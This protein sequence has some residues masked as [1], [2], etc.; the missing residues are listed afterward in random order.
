MAEKTPARRYYLAMTFGTLLSSQGP[1]AQK[2]DPSALHSWLDVQLYAGFQRPTTRGSGPAALP[3]RAAHG[4]TYTTPEGRARGVLQRPRKL[5]MPRV[6]PGCRPISRTARSTPGMK[7]ARSYE[8]CRRVR[9]SPAAPI[10]TSWC[11]TRPVRRTACTGMPSTSAPRAPG[12]AS[13]VASGDGGSAAARRAAATRRA[14]RTAV[15]EG[16]S[17]LFG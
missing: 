13:S 16:A 8:S 11:A 15:P 5:S 4:E 6:R 1:D 17:T 3:G 10:S 14:V 9:V 2:L 7:D 12:N